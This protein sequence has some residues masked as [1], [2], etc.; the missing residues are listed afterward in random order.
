M[1][2]IPKNLQGVLWSKNVSN[3]NLE[4]DKNYII[5]QILAYGN[6]EHLIWLLDKYKL[7]QVRK[8]FIEHPAKDYN[9]RSFNF[10]QKLLLKI[11]DS[12]IDKR[13]YVKT[14]PRVIK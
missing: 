5:H 12:V 4:K 2:K 7:N 6:W 3:L 13:Y 8:V 11:P 9:E 1:S 14:F 10:V